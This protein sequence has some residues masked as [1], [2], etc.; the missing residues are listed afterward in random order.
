[1]LTKSFEESKAVEARHNFATD[2]SLLTDTDET[3]NSSQLKQ[4]NLLPAFDDVFEAML[5]VQPTEQSPKPKSQ[6]PQNHQET[7][8]QERFRDVMIENETL[9]RVLNG[10]LT[11]CYR[12][13]DVAFDE[14]T[15]GELRSVV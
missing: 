10:F 13:K 2:P 3:H 8:E 5:A 9:K 7:S 4:T 12:F 11:D 15:V 1:M 6:H 14:L